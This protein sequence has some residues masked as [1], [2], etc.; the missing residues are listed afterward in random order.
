M[1]TVTCYD[2]DSN[3]LDELCQWDTD[4]TIKV[5]GADTSSAPN[6]HFCQNGQQY[7][8]VVPSTVSGSYLTATVPNIVLQSR[9]PIIVY[10]YY[11]DG[12]GEG[13]SKYSVVL[14]LVPR[15]KPQDYTYEENI[16]YI[17]WLDKMTEVNEW[18]SSLRSNA[19]AEV[20]TFEAELKASADQELA[21][22]TA[23]YEESAAEQLKKLGSC[24]FRVKD[25][26]IQATLDGV[27]WAN[28]VA[29]RDL[30]GYTMSCTDDN[31]GNVTFSF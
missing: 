24:A 5:G 25:D 7:A 19:E 13:R 16:G 4:V 2:K 10:L 26:Y 1:L 28:L 31:A 11:T 9:Y 8:Y 22:L 3:E 23:A 15:L 27:T 21:N 18:Y 20:A 30:D 17:N 29:L 14:H 6:F 12:D